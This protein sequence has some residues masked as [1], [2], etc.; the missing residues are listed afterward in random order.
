MLRFRILVP[1][2]A[3]AAVAFAQCG[4]TVSLEKRPCP[5][6][7][8]WKCCAQ[9]QICVPNDKT[10]P[11]PPSAYCEPG[12]KAE[13]SWCVLEAEV[14]DSDVCHFEDSKIVQVDLDGNRDE[15]AAQR[16]IDG[17]YRSFDCTRTLGGKTVQGMIVH[18]GSQ[19]VLPGPD[20]CKL[21]ASLLVTEPAP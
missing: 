19:R 14:Q 9:A 7:D 17:L 5:C 20:K 8:D 13:E 16:D 18:H 6:S 3:V 21:R 15:C 11:A 2:T 10:C 4:G 12:W 1:V